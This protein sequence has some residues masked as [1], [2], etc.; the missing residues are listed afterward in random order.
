MKTLNFKKT[1]DVFSKFTLTSIEMSKVHG[2]GGGD[3][4]ILKPSGTPIKI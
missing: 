3:E 2:G 1:N 4:P